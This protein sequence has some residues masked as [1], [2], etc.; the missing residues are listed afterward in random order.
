MNV[1]AFSNTRCRS[2]TPPW[3]ACGL[4]AFG[5]TLRGNDVS[6]VTRRGWISH[7]PPG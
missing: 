6:I 7:S 3:T 4:D 5:R 1:F 2:A